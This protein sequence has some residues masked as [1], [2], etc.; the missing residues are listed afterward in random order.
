VTS[1]KFEKLRNVGLITLDNPPINLVDDDLLLELGK[2]LDDVDS[3]GVRAVLLHATGDHFGPGV[4]VKTTFSGVDRRS[5]RKMLTRA[6]PIALRLEQLDVPIVCA[7]QGF[8][9]ER[10]NIINRV[11]PG[12]RASAVR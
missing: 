8:C 11:V 1:V 7:V 5:A 12:C 3:S 2:A 6:I 9:F 4:N 10:W